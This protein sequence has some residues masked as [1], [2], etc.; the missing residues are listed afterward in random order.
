MFS[1][2]DGASSKLPI[3]NP[4]ALLGHSDKG[5]RLAP[6]GAPDKLEIAFDPSNADNL[7]G[8]EKD[9]LGLDDADEHEDNYSLLLWR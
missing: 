7:E 8:V 6:E 4:V 3:E 2:S 5:V 1:P 9:V